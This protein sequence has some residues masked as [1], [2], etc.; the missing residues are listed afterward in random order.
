LSHPLNCT[1]ARMQTCSRKVRH[2][3]AQQIAQMLSKGSLPVES[4]FSSGCDTSVEQ[5]CRDQHARATL[6]VEYVR[7]RWYE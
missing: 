7:V 3:F 1:C 4:V 2:V 5:V 6:N